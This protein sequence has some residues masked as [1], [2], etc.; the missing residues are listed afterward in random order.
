MSEEPEKD[1]GGGGKVRTVLGLG[2]EKELDSETL[3]LA[4]DEERY[5]FDCVSRAKLNKK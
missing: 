4:G 2:E 3:S 5:D 1:S